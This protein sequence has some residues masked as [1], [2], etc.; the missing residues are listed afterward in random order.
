MARQAGCDRLRLFHLAKQSLVK[1]RVTDASFH[2]RSEAEE[3]DRWVN[4]KPMLSA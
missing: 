3:F 2:Q 4:A 1:H